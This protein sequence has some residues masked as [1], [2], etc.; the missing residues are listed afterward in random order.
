MLIFLH[1]DS[2]PLHTC[3]IQEISDFVVL[4]FLCILTDTKACAMRFFVIA[5]SVVCVFILFSC[6]ENEGGGRLVTTKSTSLPSLSTPATPSN[7]AS[8]TAPVS[9]PSAPLIATGR[10]NPPHGQPGHRCDIAVGAP[11][12]TSNTPVLNT[13]AVSTPVINTPAPATVTQPQPVAT[14]AN[15]LNP[16]HGQPGHR[17]DIPV[18]TS[19]SQPVAK[20]TTTTVNSPASKP[21]IDAPDTLFAKGLNPAHGK[22]G[23]RCDIAVGQPLAGVGKKDSVKTN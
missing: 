10:V 7:G 1:K 11:L 2:I 12:P 4:S 18:G 8:S 22:P 9:N 3:D 15:G 20:N 13:N 17:C 5:V 16:P 14:V 23:H 21:L 6:G 19:L